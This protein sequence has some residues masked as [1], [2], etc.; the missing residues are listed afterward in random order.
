MAIQKKKYRPSEWE[1]DTS[2]SDVVVPELVGKRIAVLGMKS[3][4]NGLILKLKTV[5]A[6]ECLY[7]LN[8]PKTMV[9]TVDSMKIL[10]Q[11]PEAADTSRPMDK[12]KIT[13][14]AVDLFATA[15][16]FHA[17]LCPHYFMQPCEIFF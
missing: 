6:V 10:D 5:S 4:G 16:F 3:R 8:L 1:A 15:F 13:A 9:I 11:A 2:A 12:Y 7:A 17:S 14:Q